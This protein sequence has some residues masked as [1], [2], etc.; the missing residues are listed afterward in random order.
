[1]RV[2]DSLRGEMILGDAG[3]AGAAAVAARGADATA[4]RAARVDQTVSYPCSIMELN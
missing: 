2:P 4:A 1:M 3:A